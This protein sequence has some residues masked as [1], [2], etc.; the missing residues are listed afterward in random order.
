MDQVGLYIASPIILILALILY[1]INPELSIKLL[2]LSIIVVYVS[3]IYIFT[4]KHNNLINTHNIFL[5]V[6]GFFVLSRVFLHFFGYSHFNETKFFTSYTFEIDVIFRT[7]INVQLALVSFVIGSIFYL[8]QKPVKDRQPVDTT[9]NQLYFVGLFGMILLTP[10]LLMYIYETVSFIHKY[11]YLAIHQGARINNQTFYKLIIMVSMASYII[12]ISSRPKNGVYYWLFTILLIFVLLADGKRGPGI[13]FL[14]VS[15]W[16]YLLYKRINFNLIRV[17]GGAIILFLVLII[18][19]TFRYKGGKEIESYSI[20]DF[21][22]KQG[23]SVQVVSYSIKYSDKIDYSLFDL[24]FGKIYKISNVMI[25]KITGNN[26][27]LSLF[28]RAHKYK[29]FS[30][31]ISSIVNPDLYIKGFGIGGSYIAQ[32]FSVGKEFGQIIV[33]FL[34]GIGYSFL[35]KLIYSRNRIVIGIVLFLLPSIIY[36][37]RDNMFDFIIDSIISIVFFLIIHFIIYIMRKYRIKIK[38]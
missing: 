24:I 26:P 37:A 22:Y 20:L 17:L 10:F 13:T 25:M 2:E 16:Y 27:D 7:L 38:L 36:I 5:V 29:I 21:I 15:L 31:Y 32:L 19:G 18:I 23:V 12:F 34:L 6:F 30:S 35:D 1:I 8:Q 33:G 14:I 9:D 11:G 3:S 4:K 28:S